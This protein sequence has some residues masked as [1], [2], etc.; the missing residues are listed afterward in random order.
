MQKE[1]DLFGVDVKFANN[2]ALLWHGR[3]KKG[4][5]LREADRILIPLSLIVIGLP[6]Y[7]TIVTMLANIHLGI[8]IILGMFSGF[9][10]ITFFGRFLWDAWH[11]AKTVYL[12]TNERIIIKYGLFKAKTINLRI[13][14][15]KGI[16]LEEYRSGVGS[17]IIGAKSPL[18]SLGTGM[19][20]W[21]GIWT[22][23]TLE[24]IVDARQVYD[25]LIELQNNVESN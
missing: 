15:I 4:I 20:W 7:A 10:L 12:I 18:A 3:P 24:F 21:P 13:S 16:E 25:L 1:E 23:P 17:I 9:A 19:H 6:T 8:V 14:K 5:I 22:T 11:R 2:E